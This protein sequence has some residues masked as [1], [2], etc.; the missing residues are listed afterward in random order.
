MKSLILTACISLILSSSLAVDFPNDLFFVHHPEIAEAHAKGLYQVNNYAQAPPM[1][2]NAANS[3]GSQPNSVQYPPYHA[4]YNGNGLSRRGIKYTEDGAIDW[5]AMASDVQSQNKGMY[6]TQ[7]GS[8][9]NAYNYPPG[10]PNGMQ[11]PSQGPANM[12]GNYA[13]NAQVPGA[14]NG[15][16]G[17]PQFYGN[18]TSN[19]AAYN[20]G[21]YTNNAAYN[22]GPYANNAAYNS[23]PY[24]NNA[25]Y[26]NNPQGRYDN[27]LAGYGNGYQQ[28]NNPYNQG[29]QGNVGYDGPYSNQQA[30]NNFSPGNQYNNPNGY[31]MQQGANTA[32]GQTA[33]N[34]NVKFAGASPKDNGYTR[35][36]GTFYDLETHVGICGQRRKNTEIVAALNSKQMGTPDSRN[37]NC[38]KT[39][40]IV[41]PNGKSVRA[42]IVDDCKTCQTGG[43][44]MSPAAFEQL[45][46]FSHG[47]VPIKWKFVN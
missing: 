31:G 2:Y 16:Q 38:G 3:A 7:D 6:A 18:G 4:N 14:T 44:E 21:H 35:G 40:E 12:N 26:N 20:N 36:E 32:S 25:A 24:A 5:Q 37:P 46:D 29:N 10:T 28:Q 30:G 47:S 42:T 15:N 27:N 17:N 11:T 13:N 22:N 33:P 9:H 19:N 43:L 39:I 41:G 45:G 23:G 8:Y 1:P 34:S